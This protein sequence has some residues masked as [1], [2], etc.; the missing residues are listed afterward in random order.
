MGLT[1]HRL[2]DNAGGRKKYLQLL[3]TMAKEES[4]GECGYREIEGQTL[5]STLARGWYWGG[6]AFREKLLEILKKK[7]VGNRNYRSSLEGRAKGLTEAKELVTL[8]FRHFGIGEKEMESTPGTYRPKVAIAW[9]LHAR[10]TVSQT[11]IAERLGMKSASNV[12]QQIRRWLASE[13]TQQENAWENVVK[14][15]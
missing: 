1:A 4:A 11:W 7:K 13:K 6:Q 8:G 10:T 5:N 14:K 2:E 12:S 15:C 3:E 9:A